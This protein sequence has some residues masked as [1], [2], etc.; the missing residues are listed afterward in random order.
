MSEDDDQD[1]YGYCTTSDD[2]ELVTHYTC[3]LYAKQK[4]LGSKKGKANQKQQLS[5]YMC[6]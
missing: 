2:D 6:D 5:D 1:D 4:H 3:K